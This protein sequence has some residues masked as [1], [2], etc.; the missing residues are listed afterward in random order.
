M[1]NRFSTSRISALLLMLT[2]LWTAPLWAQSTP[3]QPRTGTLRGT[4]TDPSG[5]VIPSAKISVASS[6][7]VT[8]ST[9]SGADGAFVLGHLVP[10]RYMMTV[11]ADGFA[12]AAPQQVLVYSGKELQQKDRKSV[13]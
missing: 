9:V 3:G 4:V 5:A 1:S 12:T 6:D 10:G 7:G 11:T 2:M 8:G 13:V